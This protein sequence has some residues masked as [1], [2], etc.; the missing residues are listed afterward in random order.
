MLTDKLLTLIIFRREGIY[1]GLGCC[2]SY[3]KINVVWRGKL[4]RRGSSST[5]DAVWRNAATGEDVSDAVV[6]EDAGRDSVV[7]RRDGEANK[8]LG[9]VFRGKYVGSGTVPIFDGSDKREVPPLVSGRTE[10]P[11]LLWVVKTS[12]ETDA[13]SQIDTQV[14]QTGR[15]TVSPDITAPLDPAKEKM[16]FRYEAGRYKAR[17]TR[18]WYIDERGDIF[19]YRYTSDRNGFITPPKLVGHVDPKILAVKRKLIERAAKGNLSL[20]PGPTDTATNKTVA[21]L[22]SAETGE[23]TEIALSISGTAV[24][25]NNTPEAMQLLRWV[26]RVVPKS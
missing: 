11:D 3:F 26:Q 1:E 23:Y 9:N 12:T 8:Y 25:I 10:K 2:P 7:L 4:T 20:R 13:S 18:S 17:N 5:F 6:L 19:E 16:L 21:F 14:D 24:G 22:A 15:S